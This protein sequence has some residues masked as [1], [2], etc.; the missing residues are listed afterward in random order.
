MWSNIERRFRRLKTTARHGGWWFYWNFRIAGRKGDAALRVRRGRSAARTAVSNDAGVTWRWLG[1]R[2]RLRSSP[3]ICT[4]RAR[5]IRLHDSL[6]PGDWERFLRRT[7]SIDAA[8]RAL[9]SR[10]GRERECCTRL[11]R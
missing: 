3:T 9:Q 11:D 5:S 10:T 7:R 2:A 6:S 1:P 4:Q 8:R